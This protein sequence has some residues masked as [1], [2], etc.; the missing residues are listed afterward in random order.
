[1]RLSIRYKF[2]VGL[3][4]IFC[5]A[6][7]LITL[8]MNR[9]VMD[10][11]KKVI[12]EELLNSQID[13]GIYFKQFLII[14]KINPNE[15]SFEKNANTIAGA[16]SSKL[17]S[18]IVLYKKD[19]SLIF[20]TDYSNGDMY[21]DGGEALKDDFSDLQ[22]A[23]KG[24]S[25]YRIIRLERNYRV[26]YS[27][28]LYSDKNMVGVMRYSQDYTEL[29]NSGQALL[30]KMRTFLLLLFIVIFIFA[31]I[32]STKITIPII[33]LSKIAKE[34][35]KGNFDENF[36]ISSKDEVGELG[37]S[38]NLMRKKIKEQIETIE[39]D[40]DDLI[41]LESHR[42]A[43]FDKVTH[44]MKTPLTIIE[45]YTQMILDEGGINHKLT[46]KAALKIKKES[47]K[48]HGMIVDILNLSK[49]ESRVDM[50][51]RE[52][53][54]LSDIINKICDDM[55]I[56][57]RK[58]EI[59]IE[60]NLKENTFILANKEDIWRM[61]VNIIDNSIKYGE[62]KSTISVKLFTEDN[63]SVITVE[64]RG[65]GISEV[66]LKKIFEP[67]YRGDQTYSAKSGGNGLGLTIV[68]SIV[69]KYEG[70]VDIESEINVGTKVCIKIPLFLQLGNK[71]IV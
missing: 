23:V 13:I 4:L 30:V 42:K 61:L 63:S 71:L 31:I 28:P 47:G 38:F 49:S 22:L 12:R 48:L 33:K 58:Y 19:G 41:K 20:D 54:D 56:K 5:F 3:L 15:S 60:R 44:E 6:F 66:E 27:Q 68:K 45:G 32:L 26:I 69:D 53:L 36:L 2:T 1:M 24:K 35:S 50:G 46:E 7:N 29:F 14:N 65:G 51:V 10:N 40:R 67:F 52:K 9:I 62:V 16:L 39:K 43:F 25:A 11:N 57:G 18:R 59:N 70:T 55:S 8:F 21:Y 17:N 34:M 64:D 37:E